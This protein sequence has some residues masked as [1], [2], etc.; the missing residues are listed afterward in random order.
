MSLLTKKLTTLPVGTKVE[1]TMKD[2][3][4]TKYIG[5][6]T[7]N[8]FEESLEITE[9]DGELIISYSSIASVKTLLPENAASHQTIPTKN[10][11][12]PAKGLT[13]PAANN[14]TKYTFYSTVSYP[15]MSDYTLD[16]FFKMQLSGSEKKIANS[17]YN[18]IKNRMKNH[19]VSG[20]D[21]LINKMIDSFWEA[22]E[23]ISSQAYRF[24]LMLQSRFNCELSFDCLTYAKAND[25]LAVYHYLNAETDQAVKHACLALMNGYDE[26]FMDML[27]TII[28]EGTVSH[29]DA[30]GLAKVL[31]EK[32]VLLLEPKMKEL[33][34]YI[35]CVNGKNIS[36]NFQKDAILSSLSQFY[37]NR[38]FEQAIQSE[39]ESADKSG[40]P[41]DSVNPPDTASPY[42]QP[43]HSDNQT[44]YGELYS[45]Q[46]ISEKGK[47]MSDGTE[48]VF[49]YDAI[50][51]KAL[52]KKIM[53]IK[54]GDLSKIHSVF[55]VSFKL[56]NGKVYDVQKA[57]KKYVKVPKQNPV[58]PP[59]LTEYP[60]VSEPISS[61]KAARNKTGE[62]AN[63]KRFQEALPLF[64]KALTEESD[65]LIAL[66]EYIHCCLSI[67]NSDDQ[68]DFLDKAYEKYLSY[69][70]EADKRSGIACN[71]RIFDL[72]IR[73]DKTSEALA[74][75]S[76]ILSDPKLSVETR[77]NYMLHRAKLLQEIAA[78]LENAE[79][80]TEEEIKEAYQ[81]SKNAFTDWEQRYLNSP[82]IT[83]KTNHRKIYYNTILF[84][85]AQ[86]LI[87]TDEVHLAKD[88]LKRIV[89]FDP[90]NANA[91]ALY[92]KLS[93]PETTELEQPDETVSDGSPV[94]RETIDDI[95]RN[96]PD[97]TTLHDDEQVQEVEYRDVSGWKVLN[98][99]E[100]SVIH[101]VFA[102]SAEDRVPV[103]AA[104]L[105][106][107][108][109]LNDAL[110]PF[111]NVFAYAVNSPLENMDYHLENIVMQYGSAD[112]RIAGFFPYAQ[113]A[114][115]IRGTFY[116]SS[117]NDYFAAS[118]YLDDNVL[119]FL[120]SLR[121]VIDIAE[122]FRIETGKGM[123]LY[124][125]YR[126]QSAEKK[127][128][129][130]NKLS[131][132]AKELRSL[133]FGQYFHESV[134]QKRFKVTKALVFE[135]DGLIDKMLRCVIENNGA[136]FDEIKDKISE[137]FIRSGC[138][139]SA[140]NIDKNKIEEF[141]EDF[142]ALAGKDKNIHERKTSTLM[143]SL[144]NNIRIPV[145]RIAEL[146]CSWA[147]IHTTLH[148][149]EAENEL[150]LYRSVREEMLVSLASAAQELDSF[151]DFDDLMS[152][153]G[154]IILRDLIKELTDR[155]SGNWTDEH[156]K[157]Y[158]ADFLSTGHVL[159]DDEYL[160]DL[161]FTLCDL[162]TFN[163]LTRIKAHAQ[164]KDADMIGY[165]KETYTR[166]EDRHDFGTSHKIAEY[167]RCLGRESEW[168]EPADADMFDEQAK[169]QIR[170]CYDNFIIDL[171]AA[172][173]R[174]QIKTSN[175]FLQTVGDTAQSLYQFC[176]D[177]HNYGFFFRFIAICKE[178]I[179]DNALEYGVILA[180]QLDR[181][182][183]DSEMDDD[184]FRKISG[185]IESQQFTV[186][187]EMMSR[188]STDD[189]D[190][191]DDLNRDTLRY[192]AQFWNEFDANYNAI[193]GERGTTLVRILSTSGAMK[194]RRGG[195]ALVNNWPR[196]ERC[197]A[198]QI[199]TLLNLLGW[200]DV[201][202]S[203]RKILE[204][205]A[206]FAVKESDRIFSQREYAHP[207]A[208]FGT[209]AY[210]DGFYVVCLFGTTD[211]KRLIDICRQLDS[212]VGNKI[213]LIDFALPAAERRKLAHMTK[214]VS[215]ANT[216]LFV[217]RV[218][219]LFLANHY[220][221]GVGDTNNRAL[222][223]ISMPF[224]YYQPYGLGSSSL[225]AP[226]LFSGRKDELLSVESP[227]G[228]NLIYGGRQLGKTAILKKAMHETHDPENGR[229]AFVIDIKDKNCREAALKVSRW[230]STE[231]IIS[232]DQVT[233]NWDSFALVIRDSIMKNSIS[234]ILLMLDEADC[235]IDD[236]KNYNYAPFVALKDLQQSLFNQF[237]FVLAGLHNIVKFKRD[238]AL[239]NNS[240]IAHLSSIN[241][242]PF[243]YPTA[244]LLL[245]EPLGYLGF[246][247]EEDDTSFMQICSATNYYPGLLQFF[248]NKLVEA[249]KRN[250]AGYN[251]SNTPGYKVTMRH[252]SKILANKEFLD[253]IKN[254][255][256]ITLRLS[257][258]NYY[259]ILALLLG[260]LFEE[261]ESPD[262]Y[263]AEDILNMAQSLGID[264]LN[265]LSK[266]QLSAL[267][268]ELCDLNI[269]RTIGSGYTF[270]TRSFRDLLGSKY[271]M[272]DMISDLCDS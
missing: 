67:A 171:A 238:V 208:A 223:A 246:D 264:T 142:W 242:K 96:E 269:L 260:M 201:E 181:L 227:Q 161:T 1:I 221:G 272:F 113:I 243:D 2:E 241:I 107:A 115:I 187:E 163:I 185:Y 66:P 52:K 50:T 78:K 250:Y 12:T 61:L 60:E 40:K 210:N 103:A 196:S 200:R 86:C 162:P 106:A 217:D 20:Y 154:V 175:A 186:A 25:Y 30:S 231:G 72:C 267:L 73:M 55:D 218:S 169:K 192:L 191:S 156:R 136:L 59:F 74:A 9:E 183:E 230:L 23:T 76:R 198:E 135:R 225:T 41:Y 13:P 220:I 152:R 213:V 199:T 36:S 239:G 209:Q 105:K 117:D 177:S 70:E 46:W 42:P 138:V 184:T 19:E 148:T 228:A 167:L 178:M 100:E 92:I 116:H 58:T 207:I 47:I 270:R 182:S 34:K 118:A 253:E 164:T 222:F 193:A 168:E 99:S 244:K 101:D 140:E 77:L 18:S 15:K 214:I 257:E 121:K 123:D 124:A 75:I 212:T 104:Y 57:A 197:S 165:A 114:G 172:F 224:T 44:Y 112:E 82:S 54:T 133:Y 170:D 3:N 203:E 256:E 49:S 63:V 206:S 215:F 211:S 24:A 263:G 89:S 143:G 219:L 237:K 65:P 204:R 17:M 88:I 7:E 128:A 149:D 145:S 95:L 62:T 68:A 130:L 16:N 21:A 109:L 249:L 97:N 48:Y 39:L 150:Q 146:V 8:D 45:L 202:V 79:E 31:S 255:F 262:G 194:D 188:F 229:Y 122:K 141:I 176:I 83:S 51:D 33:L 153:S 245:R 147:S 32:P 166:Q 258:D 102:L 131:E 4:R 91:K 236:C 195:E 38:R 158:F 248:C 251:E 160:P 247:F 28:A 26:A 110:T 10:T 64:E 157:F 125:D 37:P 84:G 126:N 43:D 127:I 268:D 266:E 11:V 134:P 173:S 98:I 137:T 189:I 69:K 179:H 151:V 252:I 81:T 85:I 155:M 240:V 226:E 233:D 90:T 144:R 132:S 27:Y 87:K 6:V 159:L 271:E 234:F 139:I 174:G 80:A 108:S 56:K 254:K 235:F 94:E 261:N 119:S 14:I 5:T 259:Y 180:T 120:P 22:D 71:D 190:T 232:E 29:L 93:A 129:T 53:D 265:K 205:G 35:Y 216:Y 111:N